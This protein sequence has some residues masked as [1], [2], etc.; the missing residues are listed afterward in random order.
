VDVLRHFT[1]LKC[2]LMP[3]LYAKAVEASQHGTPVMRAMMLEFPDDPGCDYLDRQYMLGDSLLVAPVFASSGT[4]DYYVPAGRWTHYLSG[5]TITGPG[6]RR[7]THDFFSLP[8]LVRPDTVLAVG[9]ESRKPDYDYSDGVT[10]EI[11]ELENGAVTVKVP[12]L[13]GQTALTARFVREGN[14]ISVRTEGAAENWRVLLVGSPEV[15]SVDGG[16]VE[17]GERGLLV[18][19]RQGSYSLA[20]SLGGSGR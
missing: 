4:V 1:Q 5:E 2:R 8:L 19:P 18:T 17:K 3:Y 12:D 11:Y 20:I 9:S 13:K 7:E 14:E 6:W 16:V 15:R 10:F